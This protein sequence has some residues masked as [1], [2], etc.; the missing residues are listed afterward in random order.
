MLT[1]VRV[2]SCV[3]LV[4][5]M[6]HFVEKNTVSSYQTEHSGG[7]KTDTK[8]ANTKIIQEVD[9][10]VARKMDLPYIYLKCD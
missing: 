4:E 8:E 5:C 2:L 10:P 1:S 6:C 9:K 3:V 7:N